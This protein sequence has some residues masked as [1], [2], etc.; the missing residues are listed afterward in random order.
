MPNYNEKD[1]HRK[2]LGKLYDSNWELVVSV[3]YYKDESPVTK[4]FKGNDG[5]AKAATDKA[6]RH[7][8]Q[9]A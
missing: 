5:G 6:S 4:T 8:W 1:Y 9:T 3:W 7:P 2:R